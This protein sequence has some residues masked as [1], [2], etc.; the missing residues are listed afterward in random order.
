MLRSTFRSDAQL[1]QCTNCSKAQAYAAKHYPNANP[2]DA[3]CVYDDPDEVSDA[4]L[5]AKIARLESEV[6]ESALHP[7]LA[8]VFLNYRLSLAEL[9]RIISEKDA[10][11]SLC[12]CKST[13][14]LI[15][16]RPDLGAVTLP[17]VTITAA[18]TPEP[19]PA[20]WDISN[21]YGVESSIYSDG[22]TTGGAV[23]TFD[24]FITISDADWDTSR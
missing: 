23:R 3:E 11:I 6:C 19:P 15:T 20:I 12:T 22:I 10:I 5:K 9:L 17:R 16:S 24:E 7:T 2:L 18:N 21:M 13:L 4:G 1:P 14:D 8:R